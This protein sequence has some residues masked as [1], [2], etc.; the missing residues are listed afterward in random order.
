MNSINN[1]VDA[2]GSDN[3]AEALLDDLESL[4]D[5]AIVEDDSNVRILDDELPKEEEVGVD[6]DTIE[7][8]DTTPLVKE[9][10]IAPKPLAPAVPVGVAKKQQEKMTD[11]T[12]KESV[13]MIPMPSRRTGEAKVNKAADALVQA[14]S[15]SPAAAAAA[16]KTV[17]GALLTV[18][19]QMD[20]MGLQELSLAYSGGDSLGAAAWVSQAAAS[21]YAIERGIQ[22]WRN[23]L[24]VNMVGT[25]PV[26]KIKKE[27]AEQFTTDSGRAVSASTV[28]AHSRIWKTFFLGR[29][30]VDPSTDT[31]EGYNPWQALQV[32]V[33]RAYFEYALLAPEPLQIPLLGIMMEKKLADPKYSVRDA[34]EDAQKV[35]NGVD[36]GAVA[37]GEG[38]LQKRTRNVGEFDLKPATIAGQVG[39]DATD[40]LTAV[41]GAAKRLGKTTPPPAGKFNAYYIWRA[42]DN[43]YASH[44][45]QMDGAEVVRV[46]SSQN[47]AQPIYTC[48]VQ[49]ST[50]TITV[51]HT[52]AV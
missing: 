45:T 15:I 33:G 17:A 49:D 43:R 1:M 13:S 19:M 35:R 34:Y 52:D 31:E 24:G 3:A 23:K 4:L 5:E 50:G 44:A 46:G 47:R 21:H 37:A 12:A 30:Y 38:E 48:I 2:S 11:E 42:A 36:I 10:E 18:T 22:D 25:P 29:K 14:A 26:E 20:T 39:A 28:Y 40:Y 7:A 6:G 8:I 41:Y 32:L 51:F 16:S 9:A 27:V